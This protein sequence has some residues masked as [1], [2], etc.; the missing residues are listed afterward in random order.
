MDFGKN[1]KNK[2]SNANKNR[3]IENDANKNRKIE[4]EWKFIMQRFV[5]QEQ[6]KQINTTR[7]TF[8]N[9]VAWN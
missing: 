2:S 3:K 6:H 4:N 1:N 5:I 8:T 7:K 9:V